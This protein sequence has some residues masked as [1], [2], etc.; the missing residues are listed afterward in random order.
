MMKLEEILFALVNSP[1][2]PVKAE[3]LGLLRQQ[4]AKIELLEKALEQ[5]A[6]GE[7][8][9]ESINYKDTV[10]VM[11]Q[12]ASDALKLLLEAKVRGQ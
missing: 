10:Y 11:R 9:G 6:T 2:E 12:I 3:A 4:Q 7:I 8:V 5:I 1:Y